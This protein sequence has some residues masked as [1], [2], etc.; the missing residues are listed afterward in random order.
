MR[1]PSRRTLST[2][3]QTLFKCLHASI[4]VSRVRTKPT[5]ERALIPEASIQG[6]RKRA[7]FNYHICLYAVTLQPHTSAT[8]DH[9]DEGPLMRSMSDYSTSLQREAA[10]LE[11]IAGCV[12]ALRQWCPLD[13]DSLNRFL[14]LVLTCSFLVLHCAR[15]PDRPW[16]GDMESLHPWSHETTAST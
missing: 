9:S 2:Y 1:T 3:L 7:A 16:W 4:C 12:N 8:A 14:P 13:D 11:F 15:R 10:A 6:C 5:L